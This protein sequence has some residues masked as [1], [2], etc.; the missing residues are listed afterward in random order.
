MTTLTRTIPAPVGRL[1]RNEIRIPKIKQ[2]IEK[3]ADKITR[4]L[5]LLTNFFAIKA[6]KIIRLEFKSV[7][8]ILMPITIV[9]AVR[10]EIKN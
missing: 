2:K 10:K 7:P 5:K 8:I 9:I 3:N 6:G 1:N 4:Y